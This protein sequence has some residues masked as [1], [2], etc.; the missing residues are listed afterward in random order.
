M[1][2]S[3]RVLSR[4]SEEAQRGVTVFF[5]FFL[6]LLI[7]IFGTLAL[8]AYKAAPWVPTRQQDVERMLR[9]ANVQ[10]GELVVDLGSGDGRFLRTAV[11]QFGGRGLGFELALVPYFISRL[12]LWRELRRGQAEVRYRDFYHAD[13]SSADVVTA[14]LTPRAMRKLAGKLHRELKPGSRIVSYAFAIPDWS[15]T[16]VDRPTPT[17]TRV[18]LYRV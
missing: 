16:V 11:R 13:L 7:G 6:L 3:R 17:S 10:P 5:F 18:F 2:P 12:I 15:P 4:G 1:Q 9:A 14:F 8:G